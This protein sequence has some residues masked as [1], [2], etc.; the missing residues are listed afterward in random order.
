MTGDGS[1]E[2]ILLQ[3]KG[4]WVNYLAYALTAL[5]ALTVILVLVVLVIQNQQLDAQSRILVECTT[6]PEARTPPNTHPSPNDCYTLSKQRTDQFIGSIS[7][8]SIAAAACGAAH[9]GDIPATRRCV[10]DTIKNG[11]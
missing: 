10:E 3:R 7:E 1:R 6:P 8:V 5:M 4:K 9:P 11:R 2:A